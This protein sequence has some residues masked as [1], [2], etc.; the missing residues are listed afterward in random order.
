MGQS[1]HGALLSVMTLLPDTISVCSSSH[2]RAFFFELPREGSL[3]G[4]YF[5]SIVYVKS[6]YLGLHQ[7]VCN[8]LGVCGLRD[9]MA[10]TPACRAVGVAMLRLRH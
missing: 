3:A 9:I 1:K 4:V 10:S 8:L 5:H 7:S 2:V 6:A